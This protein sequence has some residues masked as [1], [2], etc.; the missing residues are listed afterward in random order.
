MLLWIGFIVAD[1]IIML[2]VFRFAYYA[3]GK[4]AIDRLFKGGK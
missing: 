2:I 1:I 4:D 3:G